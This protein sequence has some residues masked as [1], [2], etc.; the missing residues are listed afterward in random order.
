MLPYVKSTPTLNTKTLPFSPPPA[1]SGLGAFVHSPMRRLGV[2]AMLCLAFIR[3]SMIHEA[4]ASSLGANLYLLYIFGPPAVLL[5]V[6]AGEPSR[7]L[8]SQPSLLWLGLV[9]FM[10]LAA[11]FSS[12]PGGSAVEVLTYIRTELPML[13]VTGALIATWDECVLFMGTVAFASATTLLIGYVF[14]RV[15]D[16]GRLQLAF[17]SSISNSNDYSAH[18]I[19]VLSFL[20]YF[21][22]RPKART[23]TRLVAVALLAYGIF[24]IV[25]TASRGAEI[26]LVAIVLFL[27]IRVSAGKKV[28]IA[29]LCTI[30]IA[31][32]I[33]ML[34]QE[35]LLRL[36]ALNEDSNNAEAAES[37]ASRRYLLQKSIEFTLHRPVFGVG[38]GQF[39]TVEGGKSTQDGRLGN[40]HETH[41]AYTQISSECGIPAAILYI[42]SLLSA[43]RG[44]SRVYRV[45]KDQPE[46]GDISTAAL[47]LMIALVGFMVVTFFLAFGY[48]VYQPTIVGF[49][50]AF[51]SV[52]PLEVKARR[53]RL[54]I[55]TQPLQRPVKATLKIRTPGRA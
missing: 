23:F 47:T 46:L 9:L 5:A 15:D 4:L 28:M 39:S 12:W 33:A 53:E 50:A 37:A 17:S 31:G 45:T 49:A 24:Q 2:Y 48:R 32:L 51:C 1:D 21:L 43:F 11:P 26:A 42:A 25:R 38:P 20:V 55:A 7:L 40:W 41:N 18:I 6:I 13:V 10:V 29:V 22:I 30:G 36:A 8:R 44:F 52:V 3:M 14:G 34:P 19:F 16:N 27:L 54:E 35:A